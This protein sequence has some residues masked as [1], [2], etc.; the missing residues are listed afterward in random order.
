MKKKLPEEIHLGKCQLG[1]RSIDLYALPH[2]LGGSFQ[3]MPEIG[4]DSI[5]KIGM[6]YEAWS[7]VVEVIIHEVHEFN[8]CDLGLAFRPQNHYSQTCS[9]GVMF[10]FDHNQHTEACARTGYFIANYYNRLHK[11]WTDINK[12]K[13]LK[14][15]TPKE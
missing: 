9:D 12:A 3:C 5:M 1:W 2:A 14:V 4:V 6:N 10:H 7:D 13:G 8:M 11:A 15:S